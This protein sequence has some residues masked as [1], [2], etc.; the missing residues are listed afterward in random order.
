MEY[1]V[2]VRRRRRR[3]GELMAKKLLL[4]GYTLAANSPEGTLVGNVTNK[5]ADSTLTLVDNAGGRIGLVGLA[6]QAGPVPSIAGTYL[7]NIKEQNSM[8]SQI[9][10]I[11]IIVT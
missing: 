9:T 10:Q 3:R 7:I 1:G 8:A 4:S 11:E 6:I 2:G 5:I